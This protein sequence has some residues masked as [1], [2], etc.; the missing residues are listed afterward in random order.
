MALDYFKA[1]LKERVKPPG[2]NAVCAELHGLEFTLTPAELQR[3]IKLLAATELASVVAADNKTW[4]QFL[5]S[6]LHISKSGPVTHVLS[7][8]EPK[9]KGLSRLSARVR[10]CRD[11]VLPAA[12]LSAST[13]VTL[14]P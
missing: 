5:S 10:L 12:E 2:W 11:I 8:I 4:D 1:T 6:L 9:P 14:T 3:G 13:L 7:T